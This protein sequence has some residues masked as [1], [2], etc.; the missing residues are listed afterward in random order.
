MLDLVAEDLPQKDL[1]KKPDEVKV[2]GPERK[3]FPS[4]GV[5][6]V[7]ILIVV[8]RVKVLIAQPLHRAWWMDDTTDL[9]AKS[10]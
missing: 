2:E 9:S 10:S 3:R 6:L 8:E 7:G 4:T 5:K 1:Y